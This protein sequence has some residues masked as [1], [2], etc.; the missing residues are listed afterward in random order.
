MPEVSAV[1][2]ALAAPLKVTVDPLP[3]VIVPEM[4]QVIAVAVKFTAFALA[5]LMVTAWLTGLKV[6]PDLL[7]VIMYEPLAKPGQL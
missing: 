6:K 2:E 3:P 5:P 7:G 4:L 1:V